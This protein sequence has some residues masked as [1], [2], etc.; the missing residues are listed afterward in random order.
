MG[1][2]HKKTIRRIL[3][4]SR[5][6]ISDKTKWMRYLLAMDQNGKEVVPTSDKA[7]RFCAIGA[8]CHTAGEKLL[9]VTDDKVTLGNRAGA[10]VAYLYDF[11]PDDD[12]AYQF[13]KHEKDPYLPA[14]KHNS[15]NL[16]IPCTTRL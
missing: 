16:R 6:I 9:K 1:S 7:V 12:Q 15:I 4:E 13:A 5:D 8:I 2:I 14:S 11:L 3:T 10:T